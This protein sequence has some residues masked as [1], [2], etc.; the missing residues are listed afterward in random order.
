[1]NLKEMFPKL[2]FFVV[3]SNEWNHKFRPKVDIKV[4][5]RVFCTLEN[6]LS[7]RVVLSFLDDEYPW[8]KQNLSISFWDPMIHN[9]LEFELNNPGIA[10]AETKKI[11]TKK[12][13]EDLQSDY[14][15]AM[16]S[17]IKQ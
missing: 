12:D 2:T 17:G 6:S 11:Y 9:R 5:T 16:L 8:N 14:L 13:L 3:E 7:L 1:M 4:R 15:I 10:F